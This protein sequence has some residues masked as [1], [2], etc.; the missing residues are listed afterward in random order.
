MKVSF[1]PIFLDFFYS[2]RTKLGL[3][4]DY[5][6]Y[7]A[8]LI[9][10]FKSDIT[11]KEQLKY[12]CKTLWL[13]RNQHQDKF[14]YIFDIFFSELG[15]FIFENEQKPPFEAKMSTISSDINDINKNSEQV[16]NKERASDNKD[17]FN[18]EESNSNSESSFSTLQEEWPAVDLLIKDS[19]YGIKIEDKA[20]RAINEK[21]TF[22]F[23]EAKALPFNIRKTTQ[24]LRKVAT[25]FKR[26]PTNELDIQ[27]ITKQLFETGF[28]YR[29]KYDSKKNLNQ[30]IIWLSDH[31]NSMTPFSSWE[32]TIIRIVTNTPQYSLIQ[33]HT[34]IFDRYF[35]RDIPLSSLNKENFRVFT[36]PAQTDSIF[37]SD[38]AKKVRWNKN[39]LVIF[40]SD[41]GAAKR[42]LDFKQIKLFY[43]ICK[44]IRSTTPRLL[45]INPVRNIEETSARYISYFVNM[46]Y[47]NDTDFQRYSFKLP[48]LTF[49]ENINFS[50]YES[51][52]IIYDVNWALNN[53]KNY[54]LIDD[55]NKMRLEAFWE[56]CPSEAHWWII[57][58]A[59]FPVALN[60]DLMHQI[61][62]NFQ[63]D[64]NETLFPIPLSVVDEVLHSSLV[65]QLSHD[66]YEIY[67][68]I[69]E[70]LLEYLRS[71]NNDEIVWGKKRE[72]R[73]AKFMEKYVEERKYK[74]STPALLAAETINYQILTLVPSELTKKINQ[75]L[76]ASKDTNLKYKSE[77]S[78]Q[79]E[80]LLSSTKYRDIIKTNEIHPQIKVL[81]ALYEGEKLIENHDS[82]TKT[83][84]IFKDL[85]PH[86]QLTSS[87]EGFQVNLPMEIQNQLISN[88]LNS[89]ENNTINEIESS[90]DNSQSK[91]LDFSNN[92][93]VDY[94]LL[95]ELKYLQGLNLSNNQIDDYSFLKNLTQ[96]ESLDL[97]SNQ[98]RDISF[99]Q[100]L[101]QL[102]TLNLSYNKIQDISFLQNLTQLQTLNLSYNKIQDISFLQN[103]TQLH[104]L[105]LNSNQIRDISFLQSLTHLQILEISSNLIQN[106]SF[107]QYLTQ[108]H[109]LD[110]SSNQIQDIRPLLPII[111]NGLKVSLKKYKGNEIS[112]YD[113]PVINPPKEIIEIGREAILRYF[114]RIDQEGYDFIFEAKLTLV[115]DGGSGKT[116]L[117][118]RILNENSELPAGNDRTRGIKLYDWQF[119]DADERTYTTHIWDFGGQDVYYPVHRFFLTE[120]S[121][122]ILVA[123][124]RFPTHNFEYWIPTIYQFA[125]N[126]PI[127]LVQTCDNGNQKEWTDIKTFYGVPEYNLKPLYKIDL[128]SPNNWGLRNLKG[129]IQH[130]ITE[131]PHIGKAVPRSWVKVRE[132]LIEKSKTEDYISF[133]K[134]SEL[135]KQTDSQGFRRP[136]DVEDLGLFLHNIGIILW[137]YNKD[138]LRNFVILKPEWAMNAVYKI[139]DDTIIQEHNGIISQ[140]DFYRIWA[141]ESHLAR[142]S[143]LKV[144]LQIFKIAFPKQ[145]Q[146]NNYLLPA[147]LQPIPEDKHWPIHEKYLRLEYHFDF[148]L[149]GIVNQLSADLSNQIVSD[150]SVWSNAVILKQN[151][152]Y[153]QIVEEAH[154][155]KIL[156]KATGN[157]ARGLMLLIMNSMSNII[158]EYRG[159]VPQLRVPCYCKKCQILEKPTVFEY[160]ELIDLINEGRVNV[161]CYKSDTKLSIFQLLYSVGLENIEEK[162]EIKIKTLNKESLDT[163]IKVFVTYAT[164]DKD[165]NVDQPHYNKVHQLVNA[166]RSRGFNA[167]F[168]KN[169]NDNETDTSFTEMMIKSIKESNKVI[170]ILSEG[171]ALKTNDFKSSVGFEYSLILNDIDENPNKYILVTFTDKTKEIYPFALRERDTIDLSNLESKEIDRLL[172]KLGNTVNILFNSVVKRN[173]SNEPEDVGSLF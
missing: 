100:N 104:S 54:N 93:R 13:T 33:S 37:W 56:I 67:P 23:W 95:E 70:L 40:F 113:N 145:H 156:I 32:D 45:W 108:L 159:V 26:K 90:I 4:L 36:T 92:K 151:N 158:K 2:L 150:E 162:D 169:L 140:N 29:L 128:S 44:V 80:Y 64:E 154:K 51:K 7:E 39:S 96:L 69:R 3:E 111:K 62:L 16:N 75:L 136:L 99:L 155:K 166:L 101:T 6:Q 147:R 107:S 109:S 118:R 53:I 137:Y 138:L 55:L 112:L 164:N 135:C 106:I 19:N 1:Q 41:G 97:S 129:F 172:R 124:T 87:Q 143:E 68:L 48:T 123:S 103:L 161:T 84:V 157:D 114:E 47:P 88:N 86:L 160:E 94:H 171:Y 65:R 139:I 121:V 35:F 38:V 61:W 89:E 15:D 142:L 74:I 98:I 126:S 152:S 14:D 27:D 146:K 148:M 46:I 153:A 66:L 20:V 50:N 71:K 120:N 57:C 21:A 63:V 77:A 119:K 28:I 58:H 43:E 117:Q 9:C 102:Q 144:M 73:L 165:G 17:E 122:Y 12:L 141:G 130:Q 82:I 59:S 5:S 85:A 42:E 132:K 52:D 170:V 167:T 83:K 116:S 168:D 11:S 125:G 79:I 133:E 105:Y 10:F 110:L 173:E 163:E 127:I 8:F 76:K 149:R 31:S 81:S 22:K 34:S 72:M 25:Q 18:S 60:V 78:S 131:L 115:G 30:H 24:I 134:F 91:I 49:E